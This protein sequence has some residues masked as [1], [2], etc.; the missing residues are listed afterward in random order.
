MGPENQIFLSHNI[1]IKTLNTQK[2]ETI[3][4]T[5]KKEGQETKVDLSELQETS[6][7]RL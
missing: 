5:A 1:I 3:L 6:Q 4:K 2:K 7:Q